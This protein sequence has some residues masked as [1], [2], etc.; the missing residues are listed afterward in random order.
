MLNISIVQKYSHAKYNIILLSVIVIIICAQFIRLF[1]DYNYADECYYY[2]QAIRL[3]SGDVLF[4]DSWDIAQTQGIFLAPLYYLYVKLLGY[5]GLIIFGRMIF[6]I[7]SII[8]ATGLYCAAKKDFGKTSS[9]LVSLMV[10][11]YAPFSLYT[12]SYNNLYYLLGLLGAIVFYLG[13]GNIGV[14][15]I[16]G[17]CILCIS[18][19]IH[20]AM[21][22]SYP[23]SV[24][25]LPFIGIIFFVLVYKIEKISSKIIKIAF[26]YYML[27]LL[28]V[29]MALC[30]YIIVNCGESRF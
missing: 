26:R 5:E 30:I 16:K 25:L 4:A 2:T 22:A 27:G 6:F 8:T 28:L 17:K 15:N 1:F 12:I 29:A 3:V 13:Y 11:V 21:V 24:V 18:G 23:P 19:I 14:N 9:S 10:I 20:A 7:L